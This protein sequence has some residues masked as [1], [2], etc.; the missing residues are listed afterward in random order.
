MQCHFQQLRGERYK[1]KALRMVERERQ[2]KGEKDSSQTQNLIFKQVFNIPA[3][4]I[5]F[6]DHFYPKSLRD[7]G[8]WDR[9]IMIGSFFMCQ[10]AF[11]I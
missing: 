11:I 10:C 8:V 1:A 7:G 4:L 3:I 6:I 2:M 9:T 5:D